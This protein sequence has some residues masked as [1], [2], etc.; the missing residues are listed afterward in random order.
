MAVKRYRRFDSL[1]EKREKLDDE[2]ETLEEMK[3]WLID[4]RTGFPIDDATEEEQEEIR[5]E[6]RQADEEKMYILMDGVGYSFEAYE[7]VENKKE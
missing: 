1:A 7:E 2:I 4:H 3:E 5:E 6:I